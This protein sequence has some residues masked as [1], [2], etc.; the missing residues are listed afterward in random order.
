MKKSYAQVLLPSTSD[1][2]KIKETFSKLQVN[3]I[4][5]IHKIINGSRKP[6][7]NS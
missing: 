5:N 2:L 1:I 3:K 7:P 6:K 4:N